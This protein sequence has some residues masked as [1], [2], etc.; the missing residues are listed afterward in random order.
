MAWFLTAA[1]RKEQAL[2]TFNVQMKFVTLLG[3]LM[4]AN[5]VGVY[6]CVYRLAWDRLGVEVEEGGGVGVAAGKTFLIYTLVPD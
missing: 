1:S 2:N 6:V 3:G 5:E 4:Y